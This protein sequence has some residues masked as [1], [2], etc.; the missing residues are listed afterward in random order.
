METYTL[1]YLGS[2]FQHWA[3][4][5]FDGLPPQCPD[6]LSDMLEYLQMRFTFHAP[7]LHPETAKYLQDG[8]GKFPVGSGL[9]VKFQ[10]PILVDVERSPMTSRS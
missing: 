3:N 6:K 5:T 8:V 4:C 10:G 1:L 9:R 2:C 7:H